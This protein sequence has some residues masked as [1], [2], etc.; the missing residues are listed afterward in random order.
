[1]AREPRIAA[2]NEIGVAGTARALTAGIHVAADPS[3][4]RGEIRCF[5]SDD[6]VTADM[7]PATIAFD[8]DQRL[9]PPESRSWLD[10]VLAHIRFDLYAE[11]ERYYRAQVR[12]AAGWGRLMAQ[13]IGPCQGD[14]LIMLA[15]CLTLM[16]KGARTSQ[17][18]LQRLNASLAKSG[19]RPLLDHLEVASALWPLSA[20]FG[21]GSGERASPRL[22]V[23][24]AHLVRRNDKF[25][26][27]KGHLRGRADAAL[28]RK[29]VSLR[30]GGEIDRDRP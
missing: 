11:W 9:T 23:V 24:R 5:W 2:L 13:A 22:H 4:R 16:S 3:G 17:R 10:L 14:F 30:D 26:W 12:D 18:E 8:L 15:L 29:T 20:G 7:V 1:M 25:F 6:G 19:K 28:L 27:R 21:A